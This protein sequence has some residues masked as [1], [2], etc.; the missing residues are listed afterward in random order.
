MF[1]T[2][3]KGWSV[4]VTVLFT[5]LLILIALFSPQV[6]AN[7]WI[8]IPL[9]PVIACLQGIMV[10]GLVCLGLKIWPMTQASS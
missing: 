4:G 7:I 2:V 9:V 10:G 5:P 8:A 6:P 3:W 1:K